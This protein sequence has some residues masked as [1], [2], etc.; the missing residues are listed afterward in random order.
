MPL[1]NMVGVVSKE[2]IRMKIKS[3][4][5]LTASISVDGLFG[6]EGEKSLRRKKG[7]ENEV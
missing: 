2:L 3:E 5:V 6:N 7:D 1:A 4:P